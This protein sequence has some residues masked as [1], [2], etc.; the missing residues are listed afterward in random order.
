MGQSNEVFVFQR[1]PLI[2]VLLHHV[3]INP[4]Q[5]ICWLLHAHH[6]HAI[7]LYALEHICNKYTHACM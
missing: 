2:E 6:Y 1:C 3:S 4:L 7:P 5:N